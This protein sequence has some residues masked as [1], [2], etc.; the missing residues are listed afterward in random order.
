MSTIRKKFEINN[1]NRIVCLC[2]PNLSSVFEEEESGNDKFGILLLVYD[3]QL[4]ACDVNSAWIKSLR[5]RR[6]SFSYVGKD[7]ITDSSLVVKIK[8]ATMVRVIDERFDK[9]YIEFRYLYKDVDIVYN[10]C[11]DKWKANIRRK[12]NAIVGWFGSKPINLYIVLG[13]IASM[14]VLFVSI[15]SLLVAILILLL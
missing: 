3:K 15:L 13:S 7:R 10:S 1:S 12:R 5:N 11:I 4:R 6:F 9:W 14:V 2:N 8:N